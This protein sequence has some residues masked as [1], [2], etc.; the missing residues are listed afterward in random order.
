MIAKSLVAQ[1]I[2][3]IWW[4]GAIC[5][6]LKPTMTRMRGREMAS[7]ESLWSSLEKQSGPAFTRVDDVHPLDIYVGRDAGERVLLLLTKD[8]PPTLG[9]FRAL[10]VTKQLRQDGRWALT[11]KLVQPELGKLFSHL[12]QD[13]VD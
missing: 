13:L 5:S 9:H 3:S 6:N 2:G 11:V 1:P 8:E 10:R 7:L 4:N 12:C